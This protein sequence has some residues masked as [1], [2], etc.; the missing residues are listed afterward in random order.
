LGI[1]LGYLEAGGGD[2][3]VFFRFTKF[4]KKLANELNIIIINL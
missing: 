3:G 1:Y 4:G 2:E